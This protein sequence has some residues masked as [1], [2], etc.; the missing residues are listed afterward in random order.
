MF[1]TCRPLLCS[2]NSPF[3]VGGKYVKTFYSKRYYGEN[4]INT[5][6]QFHARKGYGKHDF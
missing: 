4:M 2:Q 5:F 3:Y 6:I 1:L